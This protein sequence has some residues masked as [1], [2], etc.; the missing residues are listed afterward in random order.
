M[1]ASASPM[2]A[3]LSIPR[4]DLYCGGGYVGGG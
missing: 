4:D 1:I 2:T 3:R